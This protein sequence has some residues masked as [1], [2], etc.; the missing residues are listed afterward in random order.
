MGYLDRPTFSCVGVATGV[1]VGVV[2]ALVVSIRDFREE[3]RGV[4]LL[5]NKALAGV[6][7]SSL[8]VG[9]AMPIVLGESVREETVDIAEGLAVCLMC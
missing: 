6:F 2:R 1:L 8:R 3:D 4:I 7:S 5:F 9:E